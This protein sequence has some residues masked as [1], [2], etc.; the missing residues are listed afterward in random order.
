MSVRLRTCAVGSA[1]ALTAGAVVDHGAAFGADLPKVALL[2]VAAGAVLGLVPG[3]PVPFR[4]GA[5][6]AGFAAVMVGLSLLRATLPDIPLGR[7]LAAVVVVAIVTAVATATADRLPLWAGLLGAATLT[8][9]F[10]TILAAHPEAGTGTTTTVLTATTT[11]LLSA[12][13]AVFVTQ[14]VTTALTTTATASTDPAGE[15]HAPAGT[16]LALPVPRTA[17]DGS[18]TTEKAPR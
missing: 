3:R 6:A 8:G 7:A 18:A 15:S 4:L 13:V 2:G 11:A 1:L 10:Q 5:F 14:A 9:A 16:E 17:A 12:V